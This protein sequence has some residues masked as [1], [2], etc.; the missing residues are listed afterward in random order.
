MHLSIFFF[1]FQSH[2]SSLKVLFSLHNNPLTIQQHDIK[3]LC[4]CSEIKDTAVFLIT[5]TLGK[6]SWKHSKII[7]WFYNQKV[8]AVQQNSFFLAVRTL[9]R[10]QGTSFHVYHSLYS[11]KASISNERFREYKY[12][13]YAST[14]YTYKY[15]CTLFRI[16]NLRMSTT[17]PQYIKHFSIILWARQDELN[18]RSLL[19]LIW[20]NR[21]MEHYFLHFF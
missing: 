3:Y 14:W 7:L 8:E 5:W 18:W 12:L 17:E 15:I 9:R 16:C 20:E 1:S 19:R 10:N 21:E 11:Q 6:K 4:I 2:Y 13:M